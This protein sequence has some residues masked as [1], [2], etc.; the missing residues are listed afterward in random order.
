MSA[1]LPAA[2]ATTTTAKAADFHSLL[3][4]SYTRT[5]SQLVVRPTSCA[6]SIVFVQSFAQQQTSERIQEA[7]VCA[8]SATTTLT[9]FFGI[10]ARARADFLLF[11]SAI[12]SLCSHNCINFASFS[13]SHYLVTC[14]FQVDIQLSLCREGEFYFYAE[15]EKNEAKRRKKENV[16]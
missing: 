8:S 4:A 2:A 14:S 15:I 10:F 12:F 5:H 16:C 3:P 7:C 13:L 6:R 9:F 1:N 11:A